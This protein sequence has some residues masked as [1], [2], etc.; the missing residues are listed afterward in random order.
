L[1]YFLRYQKKFIADSTLEENLKTAD[2]YEIAFLKG[3]S[4]LAYELAF[5]HL[6]KAG[7]FKKELQTSQAPYYQAIASQD[8]SKLSG[9]ED[10]VLAKFTSA[11]V[12]PNVLSELYSKQASLEK[13]KKKI[14]NLGLA[15]K[16]GKFFWAM[17]DLFTFLI[18]WM[19]M[20]FIY[21]NTTGIPGFISFCMILLFD[22]LIFKLA[23][24]LNSTTIINPKSKFR[25]QHFFRGRDTH[26]I[27]KNGGKYLELFEKN[28]FCLP[29]LD[30][31][32][33]FL[34]AYKGNIPCCA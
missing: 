7:F 29:D 31:Q 18:G 28:Y 1:Y 6:L 21:D 9:V 33:E 22:I 3:G 16:R 14:Y 27:S 23:N 15:Y 30:S 19:S 12:W 24:K 4:Q 17:N 11:R 10:E 8:K 25:L 5:H 20:A 34:E 32:E 26:I 13:Y 2:E